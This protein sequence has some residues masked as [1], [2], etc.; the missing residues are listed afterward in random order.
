MLTL[1]SDSNNLISAR[2]EEAAGETLMQVGRELGVSTELVD[3]Q[4]FG[5]DNTHIIVTS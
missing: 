1:L 3:L 5:M 4:R 2:V